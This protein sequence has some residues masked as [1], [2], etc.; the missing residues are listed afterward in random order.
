MGISSKGW[1]VFDQLL[2]LLVALSGFVVAAVKLLQA[3]DCQVG[4]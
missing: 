2:R 3:G 4:N 1:L